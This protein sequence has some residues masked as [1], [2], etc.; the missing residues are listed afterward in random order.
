M[1]KTKEINL[2]EK[3]FGKAPKNGYKFNGLGFLFG[4]RSIV[5][6]WSCQGIGFG[7]L[8]LI[9]DEKG[10]KIDSECMS[11]DFIVAALKET[12]RRIKK[13]QKADKWIFSKK[14]RERKMY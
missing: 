12:I 14:N 13:G 1:K 10:F 3:A 5:I 7:E 11:D 8:A 4:Y 9:F 6:K 2:L